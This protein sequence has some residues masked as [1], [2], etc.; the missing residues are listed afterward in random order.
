MKNVYQSVT[1]HQKNLQY[2]LIEIW[3]VKK[4][5]SPIKIHEI[6]RFLKK[7]L[8]MNLEMVSIYQ[9]ETDAQFSSVINL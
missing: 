2:L 6:F 1:I 4:G 3:K 5:I 7:I 8:S 9:P